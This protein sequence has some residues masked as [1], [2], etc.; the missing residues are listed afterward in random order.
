MGY[1]Y[2]IAKQESLRSSFESSLIQLSLDFGLIVT[3]M[4][5]FG[6]VLLLL[7]RGRDYVRS[8]GALPAFLAAVACTVTFSSINVQSLVGPIIFVLA[9]L[10]VAVK[11][12]SKTS[13]ITED[14]LVLSPKL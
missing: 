3:L 1:S 7:R 12:T 13:S 2:E 5:I 8:R 11:T 14:D 10:A 9:G 6:F 4:L